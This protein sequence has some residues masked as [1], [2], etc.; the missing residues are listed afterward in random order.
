MPLTQ[1]TQT[2]GDLERAWPT[3]LDGDRFLDQLNE[4]FDVVFW[5]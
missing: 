2:L 1:Q 3:T 5:K 4:Q